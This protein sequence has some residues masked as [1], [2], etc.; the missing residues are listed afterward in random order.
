MT[1]NKTLFFLLL[2]LTACNHIKTGD[3]LN[4]DDITR[5]QK[6]NLLGKNEK[7]YKFYSEFKRKVAGN[8][9]TNKQLAK[10]WI[11]EKDKSKNEISFA[12]YKDIKSIDT[13]YNAGATYCPYMLI[14]KKDNSQFK[15]CVDGKREEIKLFFEE[16]LD[17]WNKSKL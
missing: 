16:A 7:I 17:E 9:F 4:S 5:I 10:Y 2:L 8:F 13:V 15:V 1:I 12:F 6:L 3:K 11:D 14:T